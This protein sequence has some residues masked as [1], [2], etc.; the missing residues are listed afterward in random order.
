MNILIKIINVLTTPVHFTFGNKVDKYVGYSSE[1]YLSHE[2]CDGLL[3]QLNS[4]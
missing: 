4:F 1:S 3:S 2:E